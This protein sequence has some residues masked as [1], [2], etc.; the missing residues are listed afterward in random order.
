MHPSRPSRAA[1]RPLFSRLLSGR[2]APPPKQVSDN[3]RQRLM[4]AMAEAV[5]RHGYEQV[6]TAELAA[7]A[8]V[9]KSTLYQHFGS[10]Q[11]CFVATFEETISQGA[12]WIGEAYGWGE[13]LEERLAGGLESFAAI[14]A[15]EPAA[16]RLVLIDSLA[17]GE[18]GVGP[19][20]RAAERF[21]AMIAEGFASEGT[22]ITALQARAI[23]A[24]IRRVAYRALRKGKPES[25]R[26]QVPALAA[27]ALGF[28][29]AAKERAV[30]VARSVPG[31]GAG[32]GEPP[33][34]KAARGKLSGR[35]R[36]VRAVGQLTAE[37]GYRALSIPAISARAGT[38]NATYYANF[39]SKEEALLAAFEELAAQAMKR[40][41]AAFAAH[42][43]WAEG[44]A[45]GLAALLTFIAAEPIFARLA[46]FE[47]PA[48]GAAGLAHSDRAVDA[49]TAVLGP[50]AFGAEGQRA[51]EVV[52]EAIGG[53]LWAS[54]QHELAHGH[55]RSLPGLAPQLAALV[56]APWE[57]GR[58]AQ[59]LAG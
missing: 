58:G 47:L 23:V 57:G 53:G 29:G 3:Q 19:R 59:R 20:E 18:A 22:P 37:Q 16:A 25:L 52:L 12:R 41:A 40:A 46:F 28:R 35:E 24:G 2:A 11:D 17:L 7:L 56:L 13:G 38:S 8:G 15:A 49:F 6:K 42:S 9:S 36:I 10:K 55:A 14:L 21:E 4:G 30:P 34:G 1:S 26:R 45:A 5:A 27:W 54:I 50:R 43:D 33:S 31:G 39:D 48:S 32:W 51:P 44:V